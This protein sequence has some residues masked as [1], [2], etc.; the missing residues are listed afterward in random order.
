MDIKAN[1]KECVFRNGYKSKF[2]RLYVLQAETSNAGTSRQAEN[3][4]IGTS[5]RHDDSES[6]S[7][8]SKRRKVLLVETFFSLPS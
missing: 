4:N 6:S 3:S 7:P 2:K 5:R 8:S 1:L